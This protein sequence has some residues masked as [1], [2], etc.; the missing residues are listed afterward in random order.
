MALSDRKKVLLRYSLVFFLCIS[1][2]AL[3][4]GSIFALLNIL[5]GPEVLN[6][7][8]RGTCRVMKISYI[9]NWCSTDNQEEF[10]IFYNSEWEK[11]ELI[12]LEIE[13]N[14]IT[15]NN[16]IN[17]TYIY[18]ESYTDHTEA[19]I[20]IRKKFEV[21][22][23]FKCVIDEIQE[24]CYPDESDLII[25]IVII[26]LPLTL[27]IFFSLLIYCL[28]YRPEGNHVPLRLPKMN[29]KKLEE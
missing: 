16:N 17:C 15:K 21:N 2:S 13:N 20:E 27:I 9:E 4:M 22:D 11:C 3:V 28:Y 7:L 5:E 10:G 26:T 19:V 18:P 23:T 8:N 1:L 29:R 24:R 25:E 6:Y 14:I 12:L